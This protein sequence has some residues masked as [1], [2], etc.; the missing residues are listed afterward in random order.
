MAENVK[1][2]HVEKTKSDNLTLSH[3]IFVAIGTAIIVGG[4]WF[5]YLG[6]GPYHPDGPVTDMDYSETAGS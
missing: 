5:L 2:A 6:D 4:L 3:L 1:T